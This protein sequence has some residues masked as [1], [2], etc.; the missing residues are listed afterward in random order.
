MKRTV[1]MLIL[2]AGLALSGCEMLQKKKDENEGGGGEAGGGGAAAPAA[3][4]LT[5]MVQAMGW[6]TVGEGAAKGMAVTMASKNSAG[7][8]SYTSAIVGE[9][10]DNW[11]METDMGLSGY[12]DQAKDHWI[13]MWVNKKTGVVSKAVLGKKG[14]A[15]KEIKI[16]KMDPPK[17]GQEGEQTEVKLAMGGP[18]PAMLTTI[19]TQAGTI[20]SWAGTDGELKGVQLKSVG[21]DGKGY[22][23]KQMPKNAD[24]D[25]GGTTCA[26]KHLVYTNGMQL[27]TTDNAVVKVISGGMFKSEIS[28]NVSGVSAIKTDAAANLKWE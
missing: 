21:T 23:L 13:G 12:G 17:K 20:K 4:D 7:E 28:G 24:A 15:G 9:D 2:A 5:T 11:L 6:V 10:G 1:G 16:I 14:E 8:S 19:K 22:E 27:W 3:M 25:A 18:Y 26:T